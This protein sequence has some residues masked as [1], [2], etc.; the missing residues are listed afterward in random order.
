MGQ[1]SGVKMHQGGCSAFKLGADRRG[2]A[3]IPVDSERSNDDAEQLTGSRR[4]LS[5]TN[6]ATR[7]TL[8]R[9][10]GTFGLS[11][12]TFAAHI[13]DAVAVND[14]RRQVHREIER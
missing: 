11:V 7:N 5:R 10:P 14:T 4:T 13:Q 12:E 2:K 3:L 9:M 6:E 1:G 8:A